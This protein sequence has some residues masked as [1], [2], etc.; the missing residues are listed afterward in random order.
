MQPFLA[1]S[2]RRRGSSA[3][4]GVALIATLVSLII[5]DLDLR[6]VLDRRDRHLD[7]GRGDRLGS[8]A[9]GGVHPA[10]PGPQ[11]VPREQLRS[12]AGPVRAQVASPGSRDEDDGVDPSVVV[13]PVR[14]EARPRGGSPRSRRAGAPRR[15]RGRRTPARGRGRASANA[16]SVSRRSASVAIPRP[17]AAGTTQHPTS[18]TRCSPSASIASPRYASLARSAITRCSN[19]PSRRHS[20]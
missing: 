17:R 6:R 7:R 1:S 19:P 11:E 9:P 4:G 20:S 5:T 13:L 3:L 14:R 8:C 18:P 16:Q 10:V 12:L 15:S 2:L